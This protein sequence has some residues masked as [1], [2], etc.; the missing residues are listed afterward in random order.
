MFCVHKSNFLTLGYILFI[1]TVENATAENT[2]ETSL[3]S[4][5]NSLSLGLGI[6]LPVAAIIM[7]IIAGVIY[8]KRWLSFLVC[9]CKYYLAILYRKHYHL[10]KQ[11]GKLRDSDQGSFFVNDELDTGLEGTNDIPMAEIVLEAVTDCEAV[12]ENL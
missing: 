4:D 7:F 9:T 6:G 12:T 8:Y 1:Y 5:N 11:Y 3:Q 10:R 2:K